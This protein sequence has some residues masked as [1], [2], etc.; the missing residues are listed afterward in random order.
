MPKLGKLTMAAA[1]AALCAST[2][3]VTPAT[4]ASSA[5]MGC[6]AFEGAVKKDGTWYARVYNACGQ[7]KRMKATVT[8]WFD[9][10]CEWVGAYSRADLRAPDKPS[11]TKD[12]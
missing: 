12:C 1:A 5:V 7:S 3:L 2:V 9:G 8:G 11:G 6:G 10:P 4:A